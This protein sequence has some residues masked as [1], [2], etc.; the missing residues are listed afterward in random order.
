MISA[1]DFIDFTLSDIKM[2]HPCIRAQSFRH[3]RHT[4]IE[5][6]CCHDGH[7]KLSFRDGHVGCVRPMACRPYQVIGIASQECLPRPISVVMTDR[8]FLQ[9]NV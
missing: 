2:G 1:D 5:T 6:G 9:R 4:V 3:L 8:L 7:Q